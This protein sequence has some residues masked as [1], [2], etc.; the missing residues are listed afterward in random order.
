[1]CPYMMRTGQTRYLDPG[2]GTAVVSSLLSVI[3]AAVSAVV[4]IILK[5]FWRPLKR[6]VRHLYSTFMGR[7]QG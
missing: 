5:K 7:L 1:M 2:T 3:A 4:A 6:K